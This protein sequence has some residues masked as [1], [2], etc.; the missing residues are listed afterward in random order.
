MKTV[1]YYF[2]ATGNSLAVAKGIKAQMEECEL[3]SIPRAMAAKAS[4]AATVPDTAAA[5]GGQEA[6]EG[7][8]EAAEVV[9]IVTPIYMHNMPH[10]VARFIAGLRQPEY[11]FV[12]YAGGGDLGGGLAKTRKQFS[13]LGLN[14]SALFNLAMPSNY[15]PYGSP[16]ESEQAAL[17]SRAESRVNEIVAKVRSGSAHLDGSG[18]SFINTYLFPGPLYQLGYRHISTMD[19]S[20]AADDRCTS[21]GLCEE[22]CPVG[23]ISLLDGRPVWNRRCEQCFGCLHWCP[24]QAIEYGKRTR[25]VPRYHHPEI[26][27]KDI[28]ESAPGG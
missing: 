20:F 26:S 14:L 4:P 9:G 16:E 6:A 10:I 17:L 12:V 21:C 7:G 2:S 27:L 28:K 18:T 24:V 8:P 11:L 22:I 19:R 1:L 5:E 15:T 3:I 13:R 25:G 23:N